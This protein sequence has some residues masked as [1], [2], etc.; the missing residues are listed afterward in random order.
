MGGNENGSRVRAR[1]ARAVLALV[2]GVA[3]CAIAVGP[4]RRIGD[5]SEYYA[6]ELAWRTTLRPYMTETSWRAY[7]DLR[8]SGMIEGLVARADLER[9]FASLGS[10]SGASATLDFNHFWMVSALAAV[11][12]TVLGLFGVRS[13]HAG[14]VALNVIL[15]VL[16]ADAAWRAHRGRGVTAVILLALGTPVVWF[17]DKAHA[18]IFTFALTTW[19]VVAFW[20]GRRGV[21]AV[22]LALASSQNP[23]FAAP[24]L[25]AAVIAAWPR[26]P[27]APPRRGGILAGFATAAVAALHPAYYLAR[28]GS[29]TPQIHSGGAVVGATLRYAWVYLLDPDVGLVAHAWP[30]L[31]IAGIGA[32]FAGARIPRPSDTPPD[33]RV[34]RERFAFVAVYLVASVVAHGST[35][36]LNSGGTPGIGR[37]ALW[38]LPLLYPAIV[39]AQAFAGREPAVS[40]CA[41]ALALVALVASYDGARPSLP[42]SCGRPTRLSR[43]LQTKLPGLYDPPAEIFAERWGGHG[44]HL[45]GATVVIGP[46]C[47]KVL[48]LDAPSH[49]PIL[50]PPGCFVRRE[51]EARLLERVAS[52]PY[53][54][55]V[56]LSSH[57]VQEMAADAPDG[58]WV[59]TTRTGTVAG[60][61]G[62]G[63]S[64]MEDWGTWTDGPRAELH[65]PCTHDHGDRILELELVPFL[66]GPR[67]SSA[68]KLEVEGTGEEPT[69]VITAQ[70][71]LS[72]RLPASACNR[73]AARLAL[74]LLDPAAPASLGLSGDPRKLGIGLLRFRAHTPD[75]PPLAAAPPGP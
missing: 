25:V 33:P 60:W 43:L 21:A 19:A 15:L 67:A 39:S 9:A 16:L 4:G 28:H 23:T 52:P 42:E 18:E 59:E 38:Y 66:G 14:F 41:H 68:L 11:A 65:V 55:Y 31:L 70:T 73:R 35:L 20:S 2:V 75:A 34:R 53:P 29:V 1:A 8:G 22:T 72:V 10:G 13:A 27:V 32:A 74:A 26:G 50:S 45:G 51:A 5:G 57:D 46:D 69:R 3:A 6:L 40:M 48:M 58:V 12:S 49:G 56:R 17:I 62:D 7:D 64:G 71:R 36:N 44:E 61:R 30:V 47:R 63:F 54:H 24:G 37:Y